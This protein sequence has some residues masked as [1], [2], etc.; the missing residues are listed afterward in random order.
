M[1][2]PT[3]AFPAAPRGTIL[4]LVAVNLIPLAGVL[5][6][7]WSLFQVVAL[8]WTENVIVGAVNL[9]KMGVSC[10]GAD[11]DRKAP[12]P[13][14]FTGRQALAANHASKFFLMPFFTVHYGMFCLVHGL[15]VA[16]LL[17]KMELHHETGFFGAMGTMITKAL[18]D[19]G[20]LAAAGL[21]I[22]HLVAFFQEFVLNGEYRRTYAHQLMIAPYGRILVLHLAILFGSFLIMALGSPLLLLLLLVAGKIA[23]DLKLHAMAQAKAIQ[24]V[25]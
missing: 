23:L 4:F 1:T 10:G 17:G 9:L 8:Y 12:T 7:H 2:S 19:G 5:F 3:A 14:E 25:K 15:F 11:S 6:W 24:P 18:A 22:G 13:P 20:W 16:A 21:L